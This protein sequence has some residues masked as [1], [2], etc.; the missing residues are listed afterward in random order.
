MGQ[1]LRQQRDLLLNQGSQAVYEIARLK[2]QE[3]ALLKQSETEFPMSEGE[4]E[5]FKAGLAE[6]VLQ[7]CAIEETAVTHLRQAMLS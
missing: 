2:Q 1:I 6:H 3:K 4:V 7:I 5:Q